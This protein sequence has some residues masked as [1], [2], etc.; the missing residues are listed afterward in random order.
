MAAKVT[1]LR[2]PAERQTVRD[3]ASAEKGVL[4]FSKA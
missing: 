2:K 3:L 4:R 1:P